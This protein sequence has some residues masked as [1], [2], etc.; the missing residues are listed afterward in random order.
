MTESESYQ[1][2]QC[3]YGINEMVDKI[4]GGSYITEHN[5]TEEQATFFKKL[6]QS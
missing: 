5:L 1:E 2:I 6:Q 3:N 4:L